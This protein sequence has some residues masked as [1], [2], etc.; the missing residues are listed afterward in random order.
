MTW[1]TD[2]RILDFSTTDNG[3][4]VMDWSDD[5]RRVFDTRPYARGFLAPLSDPSYFEKAYLQNR[6]STIAWPDGQDFAPEWLYEGSDIIEQSGQLPPR[7][8]LM[9]WKNGKFILRLEPV[10]DDTLVLHW[11][12]G[13]V[14][15][16]SVWGNADSES[17]E[18]LSD[19]AYLAQARIS[20]SRDAVTWPGGERFEAR[21]LYERS[22]IAGGVRSER[23]TAPSSEANVKPND[24]AA[25]KPK[26][27]RAL[28]G[29]EQQSFE[30]G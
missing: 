1:T 21:T 18:R 20:L 19:Q 6:G 23:Q 10:C 29:T 5:T 26:E 15:A 30:R 17:I 12:D 9:T 7:S 2:K 28:D 27:C 14:R 22:R 25:R 11:S 3:K 4:L 24:S 13:T 8:D 16:F